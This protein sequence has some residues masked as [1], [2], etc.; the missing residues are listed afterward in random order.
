MMTQH[1]NLLTTE[2]RT[3]DPL[4]LALLVIGASLLALFAL[5]GIN[6]MR[7]NDASALKAQTEQQIADSK[8]VLGSRL[9]SYGSDLAAEV[10]AL[11]PEAEKA[12]QLLKLASTIGSS[13]GYARHFSTVANATSDGVWLNGISITGSGKGVQLTGLAL[14][15]ELVIKYGERLN[16]GFSDTNFKFSTVELTAESASVTP[17]ANGGDVPAALTVTRF[18]LR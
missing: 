13:T 2:R 8:A 18:T 17:V 3:I 9:K 11:K 16:Q 6:Q 1:L 14:D 7:I 10:A 12:Q 5:A 4:L 15:K